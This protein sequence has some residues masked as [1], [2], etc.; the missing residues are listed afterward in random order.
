MAVALLFSLSAHPEAEAQ[1]LGLSEST[2]TQRSSFPEVSLT[3]QLK[4]SF[5]G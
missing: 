1:K 4:M 3:M 5:M 2:E